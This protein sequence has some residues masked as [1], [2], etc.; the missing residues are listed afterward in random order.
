M[1]Q[2]APRPPSPGQS[3]AEPCAV[4][5]ASLGR[6]HGHRAWPS[7][8]LA[9]PQ[10]PTR[11]HTGQAGGSVSPRCLLWAGPPS[12]PE[13]PSSQPCLFRP[14]EAWAHGGFVGC[15]FASPPTPPACC[16]LT[17]SQAFHRSLGS[18]H[19]APNPDAR[20]GPALLS[21][22]THGAHRFQQET[23]K[24]RHWH[25]TRG[26]AAT[27]RFRHRTS[28]LAAGHQGLILGPLSNTAPHSP[29]PHPARL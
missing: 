5:Q 29:L 15:A 18:T 11:A 7:A 13:L 25:A 8:P 22:S 24:S 14:G 23:G 2:T 17:P 21:P 10:C 9:S 19:S 27:S 20:P 1:L 6:L 28:R 12:S 26:A 3:L 4:L 16:P